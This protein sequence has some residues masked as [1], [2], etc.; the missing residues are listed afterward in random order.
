MHKGGL[1]AAAGLIGL[2][3]KNIARLSE[4]HRRAKIFAEAVNSIEGAKVDLG[5]V[6]S[7]IVLVDISSSGMDADNILKSLLVKNVSGLKKN[8]KVI[9]FTFH[10]GIS[11]NDTLVAV[12][13]LKE[14]LQK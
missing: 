8:R 10:N 5:I 7:N 9:R 1:V 6:Q 13:A 3:D 14:V 11:D 12:D 4:D 2:S